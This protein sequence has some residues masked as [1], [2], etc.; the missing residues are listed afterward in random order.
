MTICRCVKAA[1]PPS[2]CSSPQSCSLKINVLLVPWCDL[3]PF[4]RAGTYNSGL[5]HL[6]DKLRYVVYGKHRR[7][8]IDASVRTSTPLLLSLAPQQKAPSPPYD[9]TICCGWCQGQ[10][11]WVQELVLILRSEMWLTSFLHVW[12]VAVMP[13]KRLTCC[14]CGAADKRDWYAGI[15]KWMSKQPPIFEYDYKWQPH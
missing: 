12:H 10:E 5:P 6:I 9:F 14:S 13:W 2:T 4:Q 15:R 7:T 3:L 11:A 8:T 1:W